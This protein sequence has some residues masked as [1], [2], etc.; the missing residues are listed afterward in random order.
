MREQPTYRENLADV[1]EF[2]D[3]R[4]LLSLRDVSRYTGKDTRTVKT[5]FPFTKDN[6]ISAPTLAAVLAGRDSK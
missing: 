3:G 5:M 2:F 1:L 4:R 6:Y